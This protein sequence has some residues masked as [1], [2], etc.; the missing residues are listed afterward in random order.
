MLCALGNQATKLPRCQSWHHKAIP[1]ISAPYMRCTSYML[2]V[3]H[4]SIP[5]EPWQR[6]T[7]PW[8][9]QNPCAFLSL[10][11]KAVVKACY[12]RPTHEAGAQSTV[13]SVYS[14]CKRRH[15]LTRAKMQANPNSLL[16]A[17][18]TTGQASKEGFTATTHRVASM[19][20]YGKSFLPYSNT[21]LPTHRTAAQ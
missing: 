9:W 2:P 20:R 17:T 18:E 13:C 8:S 6:T 3:A 21:T 1:T 16:T 12:L 10:S 11:K 5:V 7:K 19:K 14:C 4:R 15:P